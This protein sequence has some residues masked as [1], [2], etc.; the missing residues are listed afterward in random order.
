[1]LHLFSHTKY[2]TGLGTT[3][4]QVAERIEAFIANNQGTDMP[5]KH[6]PNTTP[7]SQ[8]ME[9]K[10]TTIIMAVSNGMTKPLME[11]VKRAEIGFSLALTSLANVQ[12]MILATSN[13][14]G[15]ELGL[16]ELE[17]HLTQALATMCQVDAD[18]VTDTMLAVRDMS[19]NDM[20]NEFSRAMVKERI[21]GK[22][23]SPSGQALV[24]ALLRE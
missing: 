9:L 3:P 8:L 5:L 2:D 24:D 7:S 16:H 10:T 6:I 12:H 21:K 18:W 11:V 1:M 14:G 20:V 4:T 23:F 13:D 17:N 15:R 19:T 22:T